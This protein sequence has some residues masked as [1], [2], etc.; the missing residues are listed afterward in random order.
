MAKFT[1]DDI[2]AAAEEQ[3]GSTDIEM[4]DGSE[5]KLLNPMRLTKAKRVALAKLQEKMSA[6]S[7]AE[8][9]ELEEVD[10]EEIV[11]EMFTLIAATEAQ[12]K[13]LLKALGG[14]LAQKIALFNM[15]GE[16]TQVGE[17]SASQD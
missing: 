8:E 17:A 6:A 3:Y 11:D 14:D 9:G 15:Y 13:K 2:R 4:A 7:E 1:L 10:E 12:A 5:V 16:K